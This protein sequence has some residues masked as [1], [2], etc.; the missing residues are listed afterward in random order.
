METNSGG[1][2]SKWATFWEIDF[3]ILFIDMY[4]KFKFEY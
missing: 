4:L 1:R 3:L 2:E